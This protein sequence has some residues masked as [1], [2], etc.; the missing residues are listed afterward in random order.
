MVR[1]NIPMMAVGLYGA[2][3]HNLCGCE[4]VGDVQPSYPQIVEK[5]NPHFKE[6]TRQYDNQSQ[7]V[8]RGFI[9][10]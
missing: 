4:S 2:V 3:R 6:T 7:G 9:A 10:V 1:C 5:S 8:L